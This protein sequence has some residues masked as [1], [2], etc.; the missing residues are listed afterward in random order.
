MCV[1]VGT[2]SPTSLFVSNYVF[3]LRYSPTDVFGVGNF[4]KIVHYDGTSWREIREQAGELLVDV[5]GFSPT[6][7]W[8]VGTPGVFRYNGTTWDPMEAGIIG[9]Q[10]LFGEHRQPTFTSER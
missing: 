2:C 8:A 5:W 7:V 10:L 6:D 9:L 3:V 4:G 1:F